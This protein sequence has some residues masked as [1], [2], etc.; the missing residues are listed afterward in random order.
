MRTP[1]RTGVRDVSRA[2]A[3]AAHPVKSAVA[4]FVVLLAVWLLESGIYRADVV[5]YGV[6][7]CLGIVLL[8]RRMGIVD[9]E[10]LPVHL[11]VRGLAY[12]PWLVAEVAKANVD[13]ARRVLSPQL[14]IS[15][16]VFEV[17]AS[18]ESDLGQVFYANSITLTPGTVSI[19]VGD[20]KITVHAIAR[21]PAEGL[22]EG[23]MDRRVA[24][25][26]GAS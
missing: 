18:Q 16:E 10:A 21:E 6:L 5:T 25:I 17:T 26:E 15:P 23:T 2:G 11:T 7:S 13:V 12:V 14:P 19:L 24:R 9:S 3:G 8:S 4:L 20:G 22:R 1:V